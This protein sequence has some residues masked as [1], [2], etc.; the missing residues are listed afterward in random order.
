MITTYRN[1]SRDAVVPNRAYTI[2]ELT[3]RLQKGLPMPEMVHYKE[4]SPNRIDPAPRDLL[5]AHRLE[6]Q[7]EFNLSKRK[8]LEDK[9]KDVSNTQVHT[10]SD[11]QEKSEGKGEPQNV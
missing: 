3:M 2:E 1:F 7:L 5:G 8:E 4:Y 10:K 6:Q 9:I 11:N